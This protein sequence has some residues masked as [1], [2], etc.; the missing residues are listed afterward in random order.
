LQVYAKAQMQLWRSNITNIIRFTNK[1]CKSKNS[2]L[3]NMDLFS[4]ECHCFEV[5]L[6]SSSSYVCTLKF[7]C[8]LNSHL[9]ASW[10]PN[11]L[12]LQLTIGNLLQMVLTLF[13]TT[14]G[15]VLL[16]WRFLVWMETFPWCRKTFPLWPLW[17]PKC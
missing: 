7:K 11:H 2:C 3:E 8:D 4:F 1:F 13:Q 6:L 5:H 9:F 17:H 12:C 10:D 16:T 15:L 14:C